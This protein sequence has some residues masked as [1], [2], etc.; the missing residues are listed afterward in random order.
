MLLFSLL[1]IFLLII[2]IIGALFF[3]RLKL[4]EKE[5]IQ[6]EL[7]RKEE[8]KKKLP[9]IIKQNPDNKPEIIEREGVLVKLA[10]RRASIIMIIEPDDNLLKK[11]A[12][13]MVKNKYDVVLCKEPLE[14]WKKMQETK[15]D[16]IL[17]DWDKLGE[18]GLDLLRRVRSEV[19]FAEL[20]VIFLTSPTQNL[21]TV[22]L[23]QKEGISG[24]VQKP[25]QE[26]VMINQISYFLNE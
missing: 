17:V 22:L 8:K 3:G 2:L 10:P 26:D 21:K 6:K 5:R 20:P 4:I 25:Y 19:L 16:L 1:L 23:G 13:I 14:A 7:K 18:R 11:L 24:I 15:P 9:E 12:K